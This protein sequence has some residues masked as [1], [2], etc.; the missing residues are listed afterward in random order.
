MNCES[1]IEA[2]AGIASFHSKHDPKICKIHGK[3]RCGP[4]DDIQTVLGSEI[5]EL[6]D[7]EKD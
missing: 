2:M 5:L 1:L 3:D 6:F 7:R 4:C